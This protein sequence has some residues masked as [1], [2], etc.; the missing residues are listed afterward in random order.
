MTLQQAIQNYIDVAELDLV[1]SNTMS[2]EGEMWKLVHMTLHL[3]GTVDLKEGTAEGYGK[4]VTWQDP[5]VV[6]VNAL[7]EEAQERLVVKITDEIKKVEQYN[8]SD[9]VI[10][11]Q[12]QINGLTMSL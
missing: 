8:S 11:N 2:V 6:D 7:P 5:Q 1:L 3:D 12:Y 9:V 10:K 4:Q